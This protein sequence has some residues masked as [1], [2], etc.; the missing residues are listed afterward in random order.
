MIR[1]PVGV[2]YQRRLVWQQG[3]GRLK[4]SAEAT[5]NQDGLGA[6][7]PSEVAAE[8]LGRKSNQSGR[9]TADI[10]APSEMTVSMKHCERGCAD[11]GH[12]KR[13]V[14]HAGSTWV[15]EQWRDRC[16]GDE[17]YRADRNDHRGQHR[18]FGGGVR[19]R[20]GDAE[21]SSSRNRQRARGRGRL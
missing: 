9:A 16:P 12:C 15:A 10:L 11:E 20:V 3:E 2:E 14:Y 19:F 8:S 5:V 6:S 1:V 21:E 17:P 13:G 7:Q 18:D 4:I